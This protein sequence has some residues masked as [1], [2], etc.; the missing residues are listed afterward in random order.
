M[1]LSIKVMNETE[2]INSILMFQTDRV[3]MFWRKPLF[4]TYTFL[5]EKLGLYANWKDRKKYL[6]SVFSDYYKKIEPE[7]YAKAESF[8][9]CW[10]AHKANIIKIFTETFNVDCGAL[11]NDMSAEVSL[12]PICPRDL[13]QNSF[14]VF[15]KTDEN[16]FL[17]TM[18]H[19]VIHFIWFDI[20]QNHFKD[21]CKEY[22]S[23]HMKWILS[24]MVVDTLVKNTAIGH[25][26]SSTG[27]KNAVY[28]YFYTMK[29]NNTF[30]LEALS[31]LYKNSTDIIQFMEQ[32]YTYCQTNETVIRKQFL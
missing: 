26:F 23:P 15:Y 21:N 30:V 8:N 4:K 19:E 3:S 9:I 18:L 1:E 2:T 6:I 7:L 11:F 24:E 10:L 32:A 17:E 27:L 20:W 16:R 22:E 28:K 25:L 13:S 5:D 12:N 14:T 29:I 31:Q